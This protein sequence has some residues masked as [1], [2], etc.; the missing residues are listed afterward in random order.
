MAT[1]KEFTLCLI[2]N[3]CVAILLASRPLTNAADD[4]KA[5]ARAQL[6]RFQSLRKDRP[7]DG[8][9]VFYDAI[10]RIA[11][12]QRDFALALL[13][14]LKGRKLGLI[15]V[16]D[17]GFE[18]VWGDPEFQK[19]RSELA[20]EEAQTPNAP[21]AFRLPDPKLIPEGIAYDART[22]RFFIGS[23]AQK[24][25]LVTDGNGTV[26][27]F[28]NRDDNLDC[29]LGLA[30]DPAYKQ[31]CGV[32]TNGF[33]DQA[34]SQRRNSIVCYD[35]KSD[36]IANR[37][38]AP[39][40]MQLNDVAIAS[41]GTIYSTDSMAGTLFRKKP[42]E[43]TLRPFGT[44]GALRGANGITIGS[45]G[46]L[47]VAISIGIAKID[48]ST[49]N[50]TWLPQPDTVVTGACDGLY[51]HRGALIGIQNGTNPGRVIRIEL[52]DKGTRISRLTVLQSH[53]HPDFAE[54]T[55]GAIA[56]G[57]L[58]VIANSY[59][60]HFQPNGTIKDPDELKGTAIVAVPLKL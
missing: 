2:V 20:D 44:K 14:S 42:N 3:F 52:T 16:R 12:D 32:S 47:Y 6:E 26:Q 23:I 31:V 60:G 24:K 5:A 58:H 36:R 41:D 48:T 57:A 38:D 19:I 17:A 46:S 1:A 27:D 53:H 45:D 51:W 25:I 55:T 7:N 11:L 39:D 35:L 22:D 40:A 13:E 10:T 8:L 56:H 54:P 34:G 15:P 33:L 9:L 28:S 37:F 30:V 43:T 4:P 49:G 21:V 50:S 18:A 59:V 29:V